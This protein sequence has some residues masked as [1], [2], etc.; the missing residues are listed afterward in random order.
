VQANTAPV[1]A[2]QSAVYDKNYNRMIAAPVRYRILSGEAKFTPIS[3][4]NGVVSPD[5]QSITVTTDK[6]GRASVRPIAGNASGIVKIVSEAV[7]GNNQVTGQALFQLSVLERKSGP[8]KL[9]GVVMSHTGKPLPGVKFSIART[10]LIATSDS[11]GKFAFNDQ[12]PPG[13]IDLFVDGRTVTPAPNIE[14]PALH[15]ETA[16]IQ[17]QDNQLPHPIYL[18]PVN[19]SASQVV[20]GD[21]DITLTIPGYEGFELIVKANSV[22][23]PDGSRTGTL[24]I[25]PVHNDRLPMVPPGGGSTFGTLGWTI[26]PTGTRFDPPAQVKIPNP[27]NMSAGQTAEIVQWDHDLATFI[28]MGRATVN[29]DASQVITDIGSGITKAGWGGCPTTGCGPDPGFPQCVIDK[30]PEIEF[31]KIGVKRNLGAASELDG[32]AFVFLDSDTNEPEYTLL[33]AYSVQRNCPNKFYEWKDSSGQRVFSGTPFDTTSLATPNK[34][35]SFTVSMSCIVCGNSFSKESPPKT[36]HFVKYAVR[37]VFS[38]QFPGAYSAGWS[39]TSGYLGGPVNKSFVLTGTNQA[40]LGCLRVD[41]ALQ[42]TD[43]AKAEFRK[44]FMGTMNSGRFSEQNVKSGPNCGE[45]GP[46]QKNALFLSIPAPTGDTVFPKFGFDDNTD[47]KLAFN[48]IVSTRANWR[49]NFVDE[50][51]FASAFQTYTSRMAAFGELGQNWL[52]GFRDGNVPQY[53]NPPPIVVNEDHTLSRREFGLTHSVGMEFDSSDFFSSEKIGKSRSIEYSGTPVAS[54]VVS[55]MMYSPNLSNWIIKAIDRNLNQITELLGTDGVVREIR[56]TFSNRDCEP[57][58]CLLADKATFYGS[59]L[60]GIDQDLY[61]S[62]GDA[63]EIRATFV[64]RGRDTPVPPFMSFPGAS[65]VLDIQSIRVIDGYVRDIFDWDRD[66]YILGISAIPT[67]FI[68]ALPLAAAKI[69]AYHLG[70]SG[71]RRSGLVFEAKYKMY[72]ETFPGFWRFH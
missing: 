43:D 38:E 68:G 42:G 5:G 33:D 58:L 40:N 54:S 6:D 49:F 16:I 61:A 31:V 29:E 35:E 60:S 52:R 70:K 22:T 1:D 48:E 69:Q 67:P 39:K 2:L 10:N 55:R 11:A 19:L 17:G 20:G 47:R 4:Q 37:S 25:S 51:E 65:R 46:F 3:A 59:I 66:V 44:K 72:S 32:P 34:S 23:F 12:V 14:Y 45:S 7:L 18:P 41:V 36:V 63:L 64:I 71:S 13:K 9:R 50:A 53:G 26:Q 30:Q 27:G 21:Q 28:P 56:V 15:F 57:P 24:V 62:I 8:T